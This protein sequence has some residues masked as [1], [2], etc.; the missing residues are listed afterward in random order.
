MHVQGADSKAVKKAAP[1]PIMWG[2]G[3]Q[4]A[5]AGTAG[6][7]ALQPAP[8]PTTSGKGGF[9]AAAATEASR[10]ASTST[11]AFGWAAGGGDSAPAE[12]ALPFVILFLFL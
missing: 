10:P 6:P 8:A 7:D 5:A 11:P 9:P 3:F 4:G 2:K 1:T 12:G